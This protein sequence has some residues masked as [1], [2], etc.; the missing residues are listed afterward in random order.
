LTTL[1]V[2]KTNA[3]A[4]P[5]NAELGKVTEVSVAVP[6]KLVL[7]PSG[8]VTVASAVGALPVLVRSAVTPVLLAEKTSVPFVVDKD[9]VV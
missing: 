6:E 9:P 3:A 4:L 2:F 7:V 8:K 5:V 1:V